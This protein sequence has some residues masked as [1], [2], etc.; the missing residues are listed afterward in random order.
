MKKFRGIFEQHREVGRFKP[1][2]PHVVKAVGPRPQVD[3]AKVKVNEEDELNKKTLSVEDLAKK[4]NLSVSDVEDLIDTG[5]KVEMEHTKDKKIAR[6]IAMDH[7][8]EKPDYYKKLKQYVESEEK[9]DEAGVVR[10]KFSSSIGRSY[11]H[12]PDDE[13]VSKLNV[14]PKDPYHKAKMERLRKGLDDLRKTTFAHVK[15]D[16]EQL[17]EMPGANMD[18]RAVHQHLKKQGWSIS[19]TSGGH[20]VFT[21]PEAKHH[22]AV[23]RHRQLKAPLV[24]GILKQAKVNEETEVEKNS[25]AARTYVEKPEKEPMKKIKEG[26]SPAEQGRIAAGGGTP[27][28]RGNFSASQEKKKKPESEKEPM[29]KI[30]E[31]EE[32]K[33]EDPCWKGYQMVGHKKK[34]GKKVPNCVPESTTLIDI[35]KKALSEQLKRLTPFKESLQESRKAEIVKDIVKKKKSEKKAESDDK[36]QPDPIL[37]SQIVK[38]DK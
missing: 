3:S 11:K 24:K 14:E 33:G 31:A 38:E 25:A 32:M 12:D 9:L 15:E 5:T 37:T 30:K 29:K 19:R 7:L 17:D 28:D 27:A 34:N 36:F 18:T 22:I 10:N 8:K 13:D 21:H 16:I 35:A 26:V 6:E 1:V 23:P 2:K 20:D 4:H